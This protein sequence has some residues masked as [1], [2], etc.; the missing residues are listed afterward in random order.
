MK[1]VPIVGKF[2]II[3]ITFGL[4]TLALSM[5]ES[6]QLYT[7]DEAYSGLL[8]EESTAA[9]YLARSNRSLQAVRASIAELMMADTQDLKARAEEGLKD[10][11]TSFAKFMDQVIKAMNNRADLVQLKTDGLKIFTDTCGAALAAGRSATSP[12][13]LQAA[14]KIYRDTCQP[15]FSA[16]SPR[17]TTVTTEMVEAAAKTSTE[18]TDQVDS[19]AKQTIVSVLVALIIVLTAGFL[20]FAAGWSRRCAP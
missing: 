1:H 3:M 10:A 11:Q 4:M 13:G 6:R 19:T 16:M 15:A 17:F 9:L 18:L 20:A 5:Y 7:V 14:Q 8:D 2:L 12:D